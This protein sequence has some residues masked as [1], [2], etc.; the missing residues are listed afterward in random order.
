VSRYWTV[1][2]PPGVRS[3]F[4]VYVNGVRQELGVDYS[5]AEGKLRFERELVQQKLGLKAWLLGMWGI[6]TYKRN[7]EIDVRYDLD[8]RPMLAH[9][10]RVLPPE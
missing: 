6:G 3:P 5:V 2:L 7:D 1:P 9:A 10:L 4:E 8:G